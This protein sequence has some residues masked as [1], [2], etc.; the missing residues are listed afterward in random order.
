MLTLA[1]AGLLFAGSPALPVVAVAQDIEF[2]QV[3]DIPIDAEEIDFDHDSTLWAI[4]SRALYRLQAGASVWEEVNDSV[5]GI[6]DNILV[7]SPDTILLGSNFN[8]ARSTDGGQSFIGVYL[9]GGRQFAASVSGSNHGVIL[10]GTFGGGTGIIY[11][12]DRGASFTEATFT[13]STSSTP[14]MEDAVEIL[15]GAATGRLV[16]GVFGGIVL[17]EDSG[18][19]WAPS[20]L[21]QD[22]RFWVQRVVVGTDPAT[23]NRR[24]YITL[25]D[26]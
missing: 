10:S 3:G 12:T 22:A 21:F 1:S 24:L 8:Q 5:A 6:G 15:D 18:Q 9:D 4:T 26:A 25:A 7:L 23:G 20:S 19:T 11:S 14:F 16:A 17:S 2:E 13:V